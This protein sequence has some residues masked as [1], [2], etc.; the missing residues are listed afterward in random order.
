MR[1][2]TPATRAAYDRPQCAHEQ[3]CGRWLGAQRQRRPTCWRKKCWA[4]IAGRDDHHKTTTQ[5]NIDAANKFPGVDPHLCACDAA[6]FL[7]CLCNSVR[8]VS[9]CGR[10]TC[11]QG[12]CC[13]GAALRDL[14]RA[15]AVPGSRCTS[16][17]NTFPRAAIVAGDHGRGGDCLGAILGS[18]A[19]IVP[20]PCDVHQLHAR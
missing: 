1:S 20:V 12:G 18:V 3:Q 10:V 4:K 16:L 19:C 9:C 7:L 11:C 2:Q 14:C 8:G 17:P 13:R 15:R 5:L 6:L